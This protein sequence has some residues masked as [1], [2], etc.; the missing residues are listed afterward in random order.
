MALLPTAYSNRLDRTDGFNLDLLFSY[1][2]GSIAEKASGADIEWLNPL[3]T[4]M[5]TGDAKYGWLAESGSRP[6]VASGY[7]NT[8]LL[9]GGAPSS[10]GSSSGGLK[11]TTQ[12][13]GSVYTVVS[14]KV[15]SRSAV[16]LGA[17]RG[18]LRDALKFGGFFR[19]ILPNGNHPDLLPLFAS[20]LED[21]RGDSTPN[22]VYTGWDL[23]FLGSQWRF[24][25]LKPFPMA[26]EPILFN[27]R[28]DRLFSFN[29]AYERWQ[30]GYAVLGYFNFRFTLVP[31]APKNP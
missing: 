6:A 3:R 9:Q 30:G 28:I 20:G 15:G 1:Y 31:G 7:L 18:N 26:R 8:L 19:R 24:E 27:T 4:W 5:F 16:H 23:P 12:S 21:V 22:A 25:L 2:I 10:T 29:L 11:F 13:L 17:L 14:K